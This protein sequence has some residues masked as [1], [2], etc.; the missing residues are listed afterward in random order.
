M[1][2]VTVVA[3]ELVL[4]RVIGL[5]LGVGILGLSDG[6]GPDPKGVAPTQGAFAA[7]STIG[8]RIRPFSPLAKG[9][10]AIGLDGFWVSG[11]FGAGLTGGAI[12]PTLRTSIGF[13]AISSAFAAGPYVGYFQMIEPDG[14]TRPEDARIA[15]FGLHG[16]FAPP[17]RPIEVQ[18]DRD[19]DG[20]PDARDACPDVPEDKDGVEDEDGCPELD[21]DD[22][23]DKDG[24]PDAVD[25]CPKVAEDNDGFEDADGCPDLDNDQDGIPDA[26]DL[27]PNEPE[28]KDGFQDADGCLDLDND[29]DGFPDAVDRCPNEPET[30]NGFNDEDG[31][32]DTEDLHVNGDFIVLDDRIHFDAGSAKVK[33]RSWALMQHLAQFLGAHAEYA[34]V[35]VAGHADDTGTAPY[36]LALSEARARS[37]R[38]ILVRFGVESSRLTVE[39]YGDTHPR[40]NGATVAARSANRRVEFNILTRAP[41]TTSGAVLATPQSAS[42]PQSKA[43]GSGERP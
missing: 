37:V 25:R 31:C 33:V 27:C 36:N 43:V 10:G 11:G 2:W 18:T 4:A 40:E 29:Q 32:P 7:F 35:H 28:D 20:I 34:L 22:D 39:A 38:E 30:V 42:I 26:K 14:G 1:G 13:D 3:P 15:V 23:S 12:R 16:A 41:L 8:P 5:E 24:I 6:K 19:K 9:H 21:A 17:A